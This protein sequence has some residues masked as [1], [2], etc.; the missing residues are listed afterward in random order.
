MKQF[1]EQ[2]K[3]IMRE[4]AERVERYKRAEYLYR[5]ALEMESDWN[6]YNASCAFY[7]FYVLFRPNG[8]TNIDTFKQLLEYYIYLD[9][10]IKVIAK[11]G[12]DE[13]SE[14]IE[15]HLKDKRTGGV[16]ELDILKKDLASCVVLRNKKE[17]IREV[18][19]HRFI[20]ESVDD[21]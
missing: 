12:M 4:N 9:K 1:S 11:Y 8:L 18:I 16:L 19:E 14:R 2:M 15:I 17:E 5:R 13:E 21:Q 20:C 10:R 7:D 3:R 6:D